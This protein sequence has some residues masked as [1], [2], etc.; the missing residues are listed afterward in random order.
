[1]VLQATSATALPSV[2]QPEPF[3]AKLR[4][5]PADPAAPERGEGR[6]RPLEVADCTMCGVTR[7]LGLLVSDG[8]T[9]CADIRWYCKDVRSCTERWTTALPQQ[10]E[11]LPQETQPATPL[12]PPPAV[13]PNLRQGNK[14]GGTFHP[15]LR[16]GPGDTV[17]GSNGTGRG[18]PAPFGQKGFYFSSGRPSG[19]GLPPVPAADALKNR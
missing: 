4:L 10:P 6:L 7:P 8:G 9:A 18:Y 11:G 14:Y 16:A 1:M 12:R 13:R 2:W 17:G 15:A 19:S 5:A 3:P